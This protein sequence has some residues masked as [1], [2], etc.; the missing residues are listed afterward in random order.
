M[1]LLYIGPS[2]LTSNS[3]PDSG[4]AMDFVFA[5]AVLLTN[6]TTGQGLKKGKVSWLLV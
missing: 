2:V 1:N 4:C 6:N 5:A 3:G